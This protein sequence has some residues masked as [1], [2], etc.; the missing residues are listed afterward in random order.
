MLKIPEKEES[1]KCPVHSKETY[2][3]CDEDSCHVPICSEC[4]EKGNHSEHVVFGIGSL[5]RKDIGSKLAHKRDSLTELK[6]KALQTQ[7]DLEGY[8]AL[9]DTYHGEIEKIFAT[10]LGKSLMES[11]KGNKADLDTDCA[12]I[13]EKVK[14]FQGKIKDIPAKVDDVLKLLNL[15]NLIIKKKSFEESA[16]I[17]ELKAIYDPIAKEA[18]AV[19]SDIKNEGLNEKLDEFKEKL[20]NPGAKGKAKKKGKRALKEKSEAEPAAKKKKE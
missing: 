3:F 12:G 19:L 5:K 11:V 4:V 17:Q 9:C 10:E 14:E 13:R 7:K 2:L 8:N 6:N 15:K 18:K 20:V 1:L 16:L